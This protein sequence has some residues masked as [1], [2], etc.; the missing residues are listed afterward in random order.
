[1]NGWNGVRYE[2][3]GL[4]GVIGFVGQPG[5]GKSY[6]AM[7]MFKKA[8]RIVVLNSVGSY[9]PHPEPRKNHLPGF[10]MIA[11]P[12]D[13]VRY[14]R[15]RQRASFRVNYTP[16]D[17]APEDHFEDV[18]KLIA[19]VGDCVFVIDEVWMY[20]RPGWS[21]PAL[22]SLMFVGRHRGVVLMWTAQR[23]AEVDKSI[24]SVSTDLYVG[25]LGDHNDLA[26]LRHRMP[27]TALAQIPTL[28]DREF[29][30]RDESNNCTIERR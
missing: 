15:P 19:A 30:H 7:A 9:Q 16:M 12:R 2:D 23:P 18:C 4:S 22:K 25:R 8:R 14:L 17:G 11:T 3:A 6:K 27:A 10:P 24:I 29:L 13:L 5:T 1:M 28:R 20:Q 26:A 21:P